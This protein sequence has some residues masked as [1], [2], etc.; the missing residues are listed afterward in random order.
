MTAEQQRITSFTR[1]RY[2]LIKILPF[3]DDRNGI[4][5]QKTGLESA[6]FPTGL[7]T[8][9]S[10]SSLKVREGTSSLQESSSSCLASAQS[11]SSLAPAHSVSLSYI[12]QTWHL[13]CK[14][15]NPAHSLFLQTLLMLG[16]SGHPAN[17]HFPKCLGI[18]NW[19]F[20]T[21]RKSAPLGNPLQ[22]FYPPQA[23]SKIKYRLSLDPAGTQC[24]PLLNWTCPFIVTSLITIYH[25]VLEGQ[26]LSDQPLLLPLPTQTLA[27][28]KYFNIF[29]DRK[30][31]RRKRKS[32]KRKKQNI[33][34]KREL[35][36]SD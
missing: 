3:N 34:Q 17:P 32:K 11:I 7:G 23:L 29:I 22:P 25:P 31:E 30:K 1:R 33:K 35:Q 13:A 12:L 24:V 27:L 10:L 8:I 19:L 5:T 4:W 9:F 28:R 18:S 21:E 14:S 20:H 36:L 2:D 6:C 16:P 15:R 26:G